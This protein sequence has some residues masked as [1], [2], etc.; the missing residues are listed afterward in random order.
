MILQCEIA[1]GQ[2]GNGTLCSLTSANVPQRL[3]PKNS[4]KRST[5]TSASELNYWIRWRSLGDSNPCFRRERAKIPTRSEKTRKFAK[6]WRQK[7]PLADALLRGDGEAAMAAF[8]KMR[9]YSPTAP[10]AHRC[11]T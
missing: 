11:A 2:I 1:F 7:G 10:L 9:R 4:P 3:L 5:R 8:A 6:S